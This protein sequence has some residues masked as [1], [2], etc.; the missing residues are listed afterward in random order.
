MLRE[1]NSPA[2]FYFMSLN[3]DLSSHL[4]PES[5]LLDVCT[6]LSSPGTAPCPQPGQ[7]QAPEST[8]HRAASGPAQLYFQK[9]EESKLL[10]EAC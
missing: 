2:G 5:I 3:A 4:L 7:G 10:L 1:E 6:A 8:S 9:M